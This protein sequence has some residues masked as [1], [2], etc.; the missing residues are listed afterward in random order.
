[1]IQKEIERIDDRHFG[2]QID[3]QIQLFRLAREHEPRQI[4]AKRVLLP[5]DE[6]LLWLNVQRIAEHRRSAVRRRPQ[7]DHVR[8]DAHE[9]VVTVTRA[10]IQRHSDRHEN[11]AW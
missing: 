2:H 3:F 6:M 5:I 8:R 11:F 7:P 4:I 9:P 10:V 1:M